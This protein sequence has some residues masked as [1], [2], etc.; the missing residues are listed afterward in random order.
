MMNLSQPLKEA[1]M[2]RLFQWLYSRD[3]ATEFSGCILYRNECVEAMYSCVD[4]AKGYD[5]I[6]QWARN[7]KLNCGLETPS[8]KCKRLLQSRLWNR[9]TPAIPRP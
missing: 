9:S 8:K 6:L 2:Q 4:C 7:I 1:G 5:V 3:T